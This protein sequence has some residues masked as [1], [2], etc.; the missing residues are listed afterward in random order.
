M[1]VS[2]AGKSTVGIA[3]AETL[4]VPF[5]DADGLHSDANR[6]KMNAGTPLTDEDRWPWLDAVG[7]SFAAASETGLVLACSALRRVYRDRIRS[8]APA[9]VFVHLTGSRELLASRAEARTGHFMPA[10]LLDSQLATLEDL[11]ADEAGFSVVVD[12]A[13]SELVTEIME[14]LAL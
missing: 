2:A 3:L 7:G 14:R 11:D 13:P 10:S 6:A 4:G 1:G 8:V 12:R 5:A 9:V